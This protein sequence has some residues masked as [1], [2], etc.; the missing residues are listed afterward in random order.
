MI[1]TGHL[2]IIRVPIFYVGN[3]CPGRFCFGMLRAV[4]AIG[5]V[6]KVRR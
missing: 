6:G 3:F 5:V 4:G 1:S 2:E